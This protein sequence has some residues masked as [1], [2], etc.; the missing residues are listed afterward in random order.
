MTEEQIARV[1]H[2]ANAEYCRALG[3]DSQLGWED[4]PDWQRDSA[5][6]GVRFALAN[7]DAPPSASHESWLAHKQADGWTYGSVKDPAAKQHPCIAPY[8]ALPVEQRRKD[9]LFQAVV[10]ALATVE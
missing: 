10:R 1:C 6:A 9:A 8:D 2:A 3:D 4:A 5:V 7:P